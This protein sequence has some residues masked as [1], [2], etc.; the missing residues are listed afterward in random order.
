MVIV[1]YFVF[2]FSRFRVFIPNNNYNNNNN[3]SKCL[4]CWINIPFSRWER[5]VGTVN[6]LLRS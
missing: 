2:F 1:A 4:F 3:K 5:I 6:G